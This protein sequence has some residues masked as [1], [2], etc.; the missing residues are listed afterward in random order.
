MQEI[1][2]TGMGWTRGWRPLILSAA[3]VSGCAST[4]E[5]PAAI[6]SC[7]AAEAPV[8]GQSQQVT[9]GSSLSVA[10]LIEG[11]GIYRILDFLAPNW[12][13]RHELLGGDH[14]RIA[15]RRKGFSAGREGEA[16]QLF[17]R[18]AAQLAREGSY[19]GY[20]IVEYSEGVEGGLPLAERVAQGVIRL[21][22]QP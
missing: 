2:N 6:D 19:A 11:T 4:G 17:A 7:R 3:I 16:A 21:L 10:P 1:A 15:L 18:R 8:A 22:R 20:S 13:M 5:P 12:Q 9:C 14:V